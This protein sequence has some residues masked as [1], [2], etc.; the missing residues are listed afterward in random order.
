MPGCGLRPCRGKLRHPDP[1]PHRV[2][3]AVPRWDAGERPPSKHHFLGIFGCDPKRSHTC[4]PQPPGDTRWPPPD[5]RRDLGAP[6]GA[7]GRG[8]GGVRGAAGW[9]GGAAG[10]RSAAGPRRGGGRK[11]KRE[12]IRSMCL[13]CRGEL[14]HSRCLRLLQL[15][16]AQANKPPRPP[17]QRPRPHQLCFSLGPTPKRSADPL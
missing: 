13:R 11:E 4:V 8:W 17:R 7:A 3:G 15:L 16:S 5:G 9:V 6:K 12:L 14:T 1:H 2:G 10:A